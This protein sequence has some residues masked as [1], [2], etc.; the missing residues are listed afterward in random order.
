MRNINLWQK[1][2]VSLPVNQYPNFFFL[3]SFSH[4]FISLHCLDAPTSFFIER[5]NFLRGVSSGRVDKSTPITGMLLPE[6][7]SSSSIE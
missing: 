5:T 7:A 1:H 2:L 6:I 4:F 3:P